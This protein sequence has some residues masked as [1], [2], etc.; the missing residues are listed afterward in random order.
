[1]L[2]SLHILG[3]QLLEPQH[4]VSTYNL[5]YAHFQQTCSS[6]NPMSTSGHKVDS[7]KFTLI[8]QLVVDIWELWGKHYKC[9]IKHMK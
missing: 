7:I 4:S 3:Y 9:V 2:I 8:E 5:F 1:M 6:F